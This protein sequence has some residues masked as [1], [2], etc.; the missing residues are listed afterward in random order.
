MVLEGEKSEAAK[1]N[2]CGCRPD[3]QGQSHPRPGHQDFVMK[4]LGSARKIGRVSFHSPTRRI[5][6]KRGCVLAE[7]DVLTHDIH[8]RWTTPD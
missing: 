5:V 8:A 7:A 2:N 3:N 4:E 1:Q 6:R